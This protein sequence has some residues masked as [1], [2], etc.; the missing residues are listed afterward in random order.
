M[1]K[2][3]TY[4]YRSGSSRFIGTKDQRRVRKGEEIDLTEAE[5]IDL[6]QRG[7]ILEPKDKRRNLPDGAEPEVIDKLSVT[8]A[9]A[10]EKE[11]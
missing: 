7:I 3:S 1:P 5:V 10:V 2:R 9:P 6:S 4:I 11:G 8:S